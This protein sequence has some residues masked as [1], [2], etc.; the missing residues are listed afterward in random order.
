M[1]YEAPYVDETGLHYSSF[2]D[3]KQY[4]VDGAKSIFGE[5][6]YV[7]DDSMDGQL[8]SL[9][10]K[11]AYDTLKTIEYAYN[12][13]TPQTAMG[14]VL[15]RLV[16]LSGIERKKAGYSTAYCHLTG[17][18]FTLIHSGVVSDVAGNKWNLPNTVNLGQ[19]GEVY[20]T[21]TAQKQGNITALANTITQIETPTYGWR[22]C[23]NDY[24]ANPASKIETDMELRYRQRNSVALPSQGLVE[25]T[26]SAIFNV[27]G[28]TD[29]L[30]KENDDNVSV[31]V[32]GVTLP[33]NSITCVVKG[34]SEQDIADVIFYHKNQGCY[35]NG[36]IEV[37]QYDHY[38]NVTYI[39]FSRPTQVDIKVQ[40]TLRPIQGYSSEIAEMIKVNLVE[41]IDS[42]NISKDVSMGV[43]YTII[44]SVMPDLKEPIF[45]IESLQIGKVGGSFSTDDIIIKL[46]EEARLD[47]SN[48]T[49]TEQS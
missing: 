44:N 43:L 21:V 25:G 6:I 19:N 2:E 5:D 23:N 22:T 45:A 20:V 4:Y 24:P 40:M 30:V 15:S 10:A 41:Y 18:P 39:R 31:V 11:G 7:D 46:N 17:N 38:N 14:N 37:P 28:V 16:L 49:I 33:P 32:Q 3:I 9:F 1:T 35:T 12:N 47:A 36:S 48:I 29:C 27:E 13:T 42:L 26:Q 8:I 34:G